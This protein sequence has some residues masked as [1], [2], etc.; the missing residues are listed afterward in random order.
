MQ[1]AAVAVDVLAVGSDAE[2]DD[3][4]AQLLQHLGADLVTGAVAADR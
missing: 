2:R 1:R 4:G 3:A